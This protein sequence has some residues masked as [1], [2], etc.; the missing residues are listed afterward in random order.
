M[1]LRVGIIGTG[2]IADDCHAPAVSAVDGLSL[3]AVVSRQE[4]SGRAF[5]N[6]H[7]AARGQ[8]FDSVEG[9]C[10]ADAVDLVIIASPDRL[11]ASQAALCLEAGKHVLLEKPMAVSLSE[12]ERL[13]AL[14]EEKNRKLA[15]GFHLRHHNGHKALFDRVVAKKEIGQIRHI[16]SIWAFPQPNDENW[17]AKTEL[18]KWW[19][20]AAVGSHCIDIARW[21][22]EDMDEWLSF[23][24]TVAR[25]LWGGPHD[26][27]AMIAAQLK[28]GTTVDAMS[29]VQI[30]PY[31]RLEIF[32]SDG[33][34]FCDDTFGR[35][36]AGRIAVN[37]E[38]L[39]FKVEPPFVEQLRQFRRSIDGAEE[40]CADGAVGLRNVRD[41]IKI[42]DV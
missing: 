10:A 9:M 36:G 4:A 8:V 19:S 5:L 1:E 41:L 30:G 7:Q 6:R 39:E 3:S 35:K 40:P 14:A 27:T 33:T 11:H 22:S 12:A 25:N 18:G 17:R 34:A 42:Q 26:E 20:L 32:G 15:V 28:C 37:G 38:A 16:R 13:V 31:S 24:S 29:S 21:F 23:N 2:S